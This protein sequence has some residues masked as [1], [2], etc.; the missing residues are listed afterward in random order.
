MWCICAA[1]AATGTGSPPYTGTATRCAVYRDCIRDVG[2]NYD[3]IPVK[4]AR[5]EYWNRIWC[6]GHIGRF[7]EDLGPCR[8]IP[9]YHNIRTY[10]GSSDYDTAQMSRLIEIII[11][12]C[13]AQGVE[14]LPPRE[15]DAL[16]SR[17]G[18]VSV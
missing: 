18:E 12:E 15:L 9:G 11:Q 6:A 1:I 8:S 4:E 5:I 7:T 3:V 10:T 13:K 17:W 14:T 2:D 16:V